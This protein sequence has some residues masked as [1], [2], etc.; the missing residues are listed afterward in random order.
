MP[1]FNN[2]SDLTHFPYQ[3]YRLKLQEDPRPIG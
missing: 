2:G 1:W 3:L